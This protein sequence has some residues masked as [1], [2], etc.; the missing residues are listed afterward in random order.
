MS[1]TTN[2]S[3][4]T[5]YRIALMKIPKVGA[6]TA[7]N[8]VAHCGSAENVFRA[9][10][11]ELKN[12]GKIGD[13]IAQNIINQS[14]LKWAEREMSFI[15]QNNIK[16]LFHTDKNFPKR[17]THINDAPFLL[18][19]KGEANLN[20]ER[21]ISIV[22]TRKP[23]PYGLTMCERIVEGL[24]QY[25]PLILSGLAYGIDAA[26]HRNSLHVGLSTVG[27]LGNG[28][29]RM[30]PSEHTNLAE[31]MITEGGGVLSEYPSDQEPDREHFPMRNRIIAG[32]SDAM[33]VIETAKSGGSM[34]SA[35][36]ANDYDR[37]LFAL[38][39]RANDKYSAGCNWLIKTQRAQLIENAED[40]GYF[41]RWDEIDRKKQGSQTQLFTQYSDNQQLIVNILKQKEA[42]TIDELNFELAKTPSE[43]ASLLLELE[44]MGVLRVLPGKRYALI[45]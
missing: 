44:F 21:V 23:T 13:T 45:N 43:I 37:D 7:K 40:I 5:F 14:V 36:L 8:L 30:Y 19:Y 18:F 6:A 9:S 11:K 17:L 32:M 24:L 16:I 42:T 4:E 10:L 26:A 38:A 34:I 15:Q 25:N 20:V 1:N 27:I 22:G 35:K 29:K 41:M 12:I 33:L 28:M 2:I 3:Q 39:G 31:R